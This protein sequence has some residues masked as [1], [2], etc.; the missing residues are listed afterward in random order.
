M[1]GCILTT[2]AESSK[3]HYVHPFPKGSRQT[4]PSFYTT[5]QVLPHRHRKGLG[6]VH[7]KA[8]QSYGMGESKETYCFVL[9]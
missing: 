4:R 9:K 1:S 6:E 3:I 2:H 5:L 8:N 7:C